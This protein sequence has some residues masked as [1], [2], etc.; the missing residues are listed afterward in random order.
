MGLTNS[1]TI[2]LQAAIKLTWRTFHGHI[3][4]C[5]HFFHRSSH[6]M[7]GQGHTLLL[8][9]VQ[10]ASLHHAHLLRVH[11]L[12]HLF[13]LHYSV[14]NSDTLHQSKTVPT[15]IWKP[16][17]LGYSAL[18]S[19]KCD[20]GAFCSYQTND[21]CLLVSHRHQLLYNDFQ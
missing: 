12:S 20:T 11:P 5:D 19:S 16:I 4:D 18:A 2:R 15:R 8:E 13:R 7:E 10:Q 14:T 1:S 9:E 17:P 3:R 21:H 6:S